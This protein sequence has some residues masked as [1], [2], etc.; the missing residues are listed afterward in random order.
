M[1]YT[2]PDVA[3]VKA[4]YPEFTDVD[5]A[6]VTL[7]LADATDEVGE[8]WPEDKRRKG[9]MLY[10]AGTLQREGGTSRSSTASYATGQM[11]SR[12]VG[13][14]KVEFETREG[15]TTTS[16]ESGSD[17]WGQYLALKRSVF[18]TAVFTV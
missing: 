6:L 8:A 7:I 2:A 1:A 14:V 18:I 12:T 15:G 10:T 17:Y 4:R 11:K 5:D 16:E 13:P 3:D 9:Q